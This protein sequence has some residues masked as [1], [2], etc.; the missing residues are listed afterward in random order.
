MSLETKLESVLDAVVADLVD[1]RERFLGDDGEVWSPVGAAGGGGF[2]VVWTEQKLA[3]ARNLSRSLVEENAFAANGI[4]NRIN[5]VVGTGAE[6][7]FG[8]R[9][10]ASVDDELLAEVEWFVE[11]FRRENLW[12]ARQVECMRRYDRDGEVFLRFFTDSDGVTRL[13]FVEPES[14]FTPLNFRDDPDAAHGVRRV[15]GDAETVEGY[16][17]DGEFVVAAD[18]QHRKAHVDLNAPR[19]VP[20]YW[21]VRKNLRRAGLLLRNMSALVEVQSAIALVRKHKGTSISSLQNFRAAN[22]DAQVTDGV[23]GRTEYFRQ[24]G[25]GTILDVPASVEYDF[26]GSQIEAAGM[27]GVLKAELRAIAARLVMPEFMFTSDA[28]NAAYA[29]TMVAEGP[30]VRMFQRLQQV[31]V[32]F[33]T[34]I[35]YE[36]IK[37]GVLAGAL[38]PAAVTDIVVTAVPPSVQVRDFLKEGHLS[39]LA[40]GAGILSPQT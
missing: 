16:W 2:G 33:D 34:S 5:Y 26:P 8:P 12:H 15:P 23:S 20:L 32:H 31:Q 30:A 9:R 21:P 36:V 22:A 6:Y 18:V 7:L 35:F 17:I 37:R 13:R 25:P 38:P 19:G 11:S 1:D 4:E 24:Y 14:V 3:S 27:V 10:G 39:R 29:S 28:S 40:F